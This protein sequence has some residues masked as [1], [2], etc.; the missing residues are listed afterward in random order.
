MVQKPPMHQ[1]DSSGSGGKKHKRTNS[2]VDQM[3]EEIF[4]KLESG[5]DGSLDSVKGLVLELKKLMTPSSGTQTR[6]RG[7]VEYKP[8]HILNSVL[9][10]DNLRPVPTAS[11][12]EHDETDFLKIVTVQK[13]GLVSSVEWRLLFFVRLA[14]KIQIGSG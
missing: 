8:I 12:V 7:G 6:K 14:G 3:F 11:G 13:L 5:H 2:K 1:P 4:D 10:A 9:L